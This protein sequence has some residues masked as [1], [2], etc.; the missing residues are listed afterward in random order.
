MEVEFIPIEK[1]DVKKVK[2]QRRSSKEVSGRGIP[3]RKFR[4]LMGE[5]KYD[6]GIFYCDADKETGVK[7]S[8]RIA[9]TKHYE[10]VYKEV[11]DGLNSDKGI[12]MIPLSMIECWILADKSALEQVFELE[13]QQAKMPAEPEYIWGNKNDSGSDYPKNYLVRMIRSLDNRYQTYAASR[14][15][16]YEIAK[17]SEI[18]TLREKCSISYERFYKDFEQILS[19]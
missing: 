7:S 19:K 5:G 15:N 4:I 9:V 16:F 14:E 3:A 12:P 2:L 18:S 11:K 1:E 13:I 17:C 6:A 10:T 8:N